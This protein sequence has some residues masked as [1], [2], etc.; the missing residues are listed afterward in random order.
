MPDKPHYT[1]RTDA[2]PSSELKRNGALLRATTELFV[3]ELAH[4]ADEGRRYEELALHFLPRVAV[5]DRL[6][7]AELLASRLDAPQAV[8]RMLAKD[9]IEVAGPVLRRSPVLSALD[10]LA[11]IAGTGIEHHRLVARRPSLSSEVERALRLLADPK[12][13][14]EMDAA[15]PPAPLPPA[16]TISHARPTATPI[17]TQPMAPIATPPPVAAPSA[18]A[19]AQPSEPTAPEPAETAEAATSSETP[20]DWF[21]HRHAVRFGPDRFDPWLFLSLDRP[22]RLRLMA[23]LAMRPPVRRYSGS[24]S[25]LD[26]AF[27]SILGA[28]QIVGYARSGQKAAL[29]SAVADSLGLGKDLVQASLDDPSGESLAVMLK[30][31]S[32]DNVQAQQVFLL[33]SSVVGHEVTTFFKLADL[34]AGMEPVVAETLVEA[35]RGEARIS[36]PRHAPLFAENGQVRRTGLGEAARTRLPP[37]ADQASR[38]RA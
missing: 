30:A 19:A 28:A 33:A 18:S 2:S 37:A 12:V 17:A 9:K 20:N 24:A 29:V 14:A 13:I 38:D 4:D 26:R 16:P 31:L 11:V 35:W 32:L 6:F 5:E 3:Q 1:G 8:I 22:A 23:E 21:G 36:P 15:R 34:Y 25:R 7:V 10:L 27:R